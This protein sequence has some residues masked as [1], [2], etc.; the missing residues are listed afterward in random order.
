MLMNSSRSD[1]NTNSHYTNYALAAFAV[2]AALVN[3]T[4]LILIV[5][6][7]DTSMN[8]MQIECYS[9]QIWQGILYPRWCMNANSGLGSPA[10][11]FYFPLPYY[12]TALFAP[13]ASIEIG[14]LNLGSIEIGSF[15]SSV[16]SSKWQ[17]TVEWQY[18][19]GFYLANCVS[20]ICCYNWLSRFTSRNTALFGA[21]IFLLG[22]YRS[23]LITRGSYA[24]YWCVAFMPLIFMYAHDACNGAFKCWKKLSAAIIICMFCHAPATVMALLAAGTY[25]LL[26]NWRSLGTL[27]FS[28]LI[29]TMAGLFH[30]L[31]TKLFADSLNQEG[32]GHKFWQN[33]WINSFIDNLYIHTG[34]RY[35]WAIAGFAIG[36]AA[37]III[38]FIALKN[39]KKLPP[40][41]ASISKRWII[42]SLLATFMMF[43][44]SAPLWKIIT[45]ISDVATPWRMQVLI[46][47][48]IVVNF[49][50]L[51]EYLWFK[52]P[53]SQY[54]DKIICSLFFVFLFL[55]YFG[56]VVKESLPLYKKLVPENFATAFFLPADVDKKYKEADIFFADF[57]WRENRPQAEWIKGSGDIKIEQW[58]DKA[59]I[60]SGNSE[61]NGALRIS[62]FYYPLWQATINNRPATIKAEKSKGRMLLEIPKGKFTLTLTTE[63]WKMFSRYKP[64]S[65]E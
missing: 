7:G 34:D 10:P 17:Y 11:I 12:I 36:L 14:N 25:M 64:L 62:H 32:G 16:I 28:C 44:I 31:P 52:N 41:G 60:I 43:S 50:I 65:T 18:V 54:G 20:F 46:M 1:K 19:L 58:N 57:S 6:S 38:S 42:I 53:R 33:S 24:E 3:L 55:Y 61:S 5:P 13:L 21:F 2:I 26:G 45:I 30:Y 40:E 9:Q 63:Y 39:R 27:A 4:P 48:A 51:S 35:S 8:Y 15:L 22:F 59:I 47:F 49:S 29:A 56:G 23:E 37:N